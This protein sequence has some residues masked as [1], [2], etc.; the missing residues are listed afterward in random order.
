MRILI[1]R[2]RADA[3]PLAATLI[4]HGHDAI[5]EPM[6]DI[7]PVTGRPLNLDGVQAV[8]ATSANGVRA[9]AGVSDER[10]MPIY[11]VG[12]ATARQALALDF[13]NIRSAAGD[14]RSLSTLV[15]RD[16]DPRDGTLIHVAGSHLA[17]DLTSELQRR[18]FTIRREVLYCA[19][20]ARRL[21]DHVRAAL[22]GGAID[23]IMFFSPRS[24]DIFVNL[25]VQA[26]L[27]PACRGTAALCLSKAVADNVTSLP[28]ARVAIA[29]EPTQASLL[30]LIGIGP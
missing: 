16:F 6:L 27:G 13:T 22:S 18:K 23:A 12:D 20:A 29:S 3:E 7:R 5:I 24:A 25:V 26:E 17:G 1:T 10:A 8:L 28:W 2:P 14:V 15:A 21:S 19:R 30:K 9:L 11:A 4:A